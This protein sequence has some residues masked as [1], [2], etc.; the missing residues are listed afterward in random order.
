MRLLV[1]WEYLALGGKENN[2]LFGL[3]GSGIG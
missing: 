3:K 1:C 2:G